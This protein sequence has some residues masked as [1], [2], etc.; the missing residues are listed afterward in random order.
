MINFTLQTINNYTFTSL[1][2]LH[3]HGFENIKNKN[4]KLID[5]EPLTKN[6][7]KIDKRLGCIMDEWRKY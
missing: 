4:G 5:L 6:A 1:N 3:L 7:F 2:N